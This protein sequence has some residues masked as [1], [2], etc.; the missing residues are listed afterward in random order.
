[1]IP[2]LALQQAVRARLLADP[3]IS[4]SVLPERIRAGDRRPSEFPSIILSPARTEILGRA[5]GGQIVAEV[6]AM[7]HVWADADGSGTGEG[8]A[9]GVFM[10]LIDAPEA[11]GFE[12]DEWQRPH[13][14]WVDQAGAVANASFGTVALRATIRWRDQ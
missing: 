2:S 3:F 14:T 4:A 5:A 13:L 6:S 12:I 8:I 11:E 1:M 7:L 10:A 9:A